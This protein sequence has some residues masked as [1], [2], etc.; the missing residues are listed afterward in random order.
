[1]AW[2]C[3]NWSSLEINQLNLL[4]PLFLQF[5]KFAKL[6]ARWW[7]LGRS[8]VDTWVAGHSEVKQMYVQNRAPT[9]Q[10][11]AQIVW[12]KSESNQFISV[13]FEF[14]V[15]AKYSCTFLK[16]SLIRHLARPETSAAKFFLRNSE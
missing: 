3:K 12:A 14:Q 5:R 11:F 16:L 9:Q 2:A 4:P 13:V 10:I 8:L 15:I 7:T 1:M 6:D